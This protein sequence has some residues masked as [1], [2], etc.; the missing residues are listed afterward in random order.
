MCGRTTR[1]WWA[2]YY[3]LHGVEEFS[4]TDI[5]PRFNIAPTQEV[6]HIRAEQGRRR[7][8][9]SWWGLIPAWAK[10]RTIG[11]KMF[12][13]RA[14]TVLE[15]PSFRG[16]A[17]KHRCIIPISGFYEWRK[18]GKSRQPLYIHA[19][20]GQS[21]ALAGLW[22]TWRDP[23]GGTPVTSHTVLTC[24][25]NEFMASIHDRM[26]VILDRDGVNDWLDEATVDPGA[27]MGL[28]RACPDEVLVAHPVSALVNNVRNLGAELIEPVD[29]A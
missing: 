14:E 7:L 8:L 29:A 24:A 1:Q 20:D 2:D 26:P 18:Q 5:V 13:A 12:N 16:L 27:V 22:T 3:D 11:G 23:A 17:A 25:P 10:D 4:E 9:A 6:W 19:R 21:L 15:K 28:L